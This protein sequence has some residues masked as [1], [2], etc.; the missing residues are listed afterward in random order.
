MSQDVLAQKIAK[1]K[2]TC[3]K[4]NAPEWFFGEYITPKRVLGM[5][6]RA[7]IAGKQVFLSAMRVHHVNPY[8]TGINPY[9]G[10]I[11]FHVGVTQNLLTV[12]AMD[13]TEKC[14]LASLEFGGAKGG[15]AFDPLLCSARELRDI[16]EQMTME[17]LKDNIPHPDIDV[18]GPDVGTDSRVMYWM[19]NKA[20]EMSHFRTVP[21]ALALV[22]GKPLTD[23]GIP[24]RV[25]ATARG[26]LIHLE[27]FFELSKMR[28]TSAPMLVIQGFGNVGSNLVRLIRDNPKLFRYK[29]AAVSDVSG[30]AYRKTGLSLPDIIAWYEK[31][32]S[33]K[34]YREADSVTNKELLL[35]PSDVLIPAAI[36]G[37]ITEKNAAKIKAR[38]IVEGANEAITPDALQILADR[39]IPV[40]PGV[41][42]NAGGVIVSSFEWRKNR[43]DRPHEVDR[44]AIG[45]WVIRELNAVMRRSLEKA[46][47][48]SITLKCSLPDAADM[49]ALE[50]IRDKLAWKHSYLK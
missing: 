4:I 23:G 29:I 45:R 9:K 7:Q 28:R 12:L 50:I 19:L 21:N 38:L 26:A 41:L 42:A 49:L 30:G 16:T 25:E 6:I 24:G 2:K 11:R 47:K 13:M 43:G 5:K 10:G 3:E 46:F 17:M 32:G 44:E 18:P 36:E 15:I 8:S 48:R 37:Q 1:I 14:A 27:Y 35:L 22:T 20:A 39:R 40:I 34:G 31:H 33:F